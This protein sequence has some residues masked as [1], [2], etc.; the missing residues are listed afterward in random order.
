MST[1]SILHERVNSATISRMKHNQ[2]GAV[3]VLVIPLIVSVLLFIAAAVFG[4]WA[5]SGRQDYKNNVD[6]K[7][8]A[9]VA[10]AKQQQ[11]NQ[12][13]QTFAKEEEQP[14]KT[15][16][17]PQEY[18]AIVVNYPKT[19]SSYVDSTGNGQALVDGYF[20]PG[21]VPSISGSNSV[22][23]LRVQVI[24]TSY[25]EE[26]QNYTGEQQS[27]QAAVV[28]Y[29]LPK[30]PSVVGVKVTGQLSDGNSG[31]M[32]ILP[33]RNNTIEIWT[34]GTQFLSDFNNNILANFSFSP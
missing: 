7:I 34:D 17:G 11:Q 8:S 4:Y 13:N 12:D 24:G 20:Y 27:G 14:L 10:T 28:P 19:W 2:V 29:S 22:F 26:L 30:V 5:Y 3:N 16:T 23:A 18:G 1:S 15:Y 9:A 33:E 25:S 21:T 31:T 32:I 6:Q